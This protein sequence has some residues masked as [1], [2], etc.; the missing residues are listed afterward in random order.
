MW[1]DEVLKNLWIECE[2][3][4]NL[5]I[6][7]SLDLSRDEGMKSKLRMGFVIITNDK[8]CIGKDVY[9]FDMKRESS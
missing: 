8:Y 3:M 9:E 2:L 4:N 1:R 6:S 7:Q 5:S